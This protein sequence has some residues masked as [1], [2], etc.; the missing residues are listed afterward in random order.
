MLKKWVAASAAVMLLVSGC[1]KK[2]EINKHKPRVVENAVKEVKEEPFPYQFPLT[3]IG[4]KAEASGRAVAVMV[5]NHPLARPQSGLHKAD[6]VYE[7]LA[8]GD[9][10]RFL[11]IFQSEKPENI[12]PVRSARDYYMELAKGYDSFFVAHGYSPEAQDM[13]KRGFIDNINGMQ[14]D[15]TL[16]KR[17]DFR[18][19]PHNSYITYENILAGA[20]KNGYEMADVPEALPFLTEADAGKL[21]GAAAKSVNVSYTSTEFDVQYQ[22]DDEKQKY[23]RYTG[24]QETTDLDSK[25]SVLLDNLFIVEADH[26]VIDEAAH[27]EIDLTSGGKGWLIQKGVA[28]EVQWKNVDGK[29]LPYVNGAAAGLLPGKTWINVIPS[30]PGIS[31][32]VTFGA[33]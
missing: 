5:N 23:R 31:Q 10:T 1:A 19:A 17:A 8:E 7:V 3:G 27:K 6:I 13:I 32:L 30:K 22:Y 28:N 12:G 14:Y 2:E 26:R 15:G 16:F 4:T 20:E 24:G 21:A 11:A 25:E 33:E 29:I 9:V 18:K